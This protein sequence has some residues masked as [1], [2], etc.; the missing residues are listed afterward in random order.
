MGNHQKASGFGETEGD[1][2][3]LALRVI[4]VGTGGGERVQGDGGGL[5]EADAVLTE[6][7]GLELEEC[8]V[9]VFVFCCYCEIAK[10]VTCRFSRCCR[11]CQRS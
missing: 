1:P 7:G 3:R 2:P 9:N 11:I 6:V 4:R 8:L 5:F 10:G